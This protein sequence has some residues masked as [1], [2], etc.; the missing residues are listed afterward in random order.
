MR[1]VN[2]SLLALLVAGASGTSQAGIDPAKL[3]PPAAKQGITFAADIQPLFEASCLRCHGADKPKGGLRLD[4]LEGVL[5]GSKEGKVVI[6]GK[7]ETSPLLIAVSHLDPEM[8]MPP[9]PK[10]GKGNAAGNP[11]GPGGQGKG[12]PPPKPLTPEQVGLVRAWI[13]QGAK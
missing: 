13:N 12:G 1:I 4:S 2:A 3:P 7:A 6:P 11:G 9:K 5:R 8:A 10:P